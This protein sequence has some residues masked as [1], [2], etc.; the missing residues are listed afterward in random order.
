VTGHQGLGKKILS[1]TLET[2]TI[3]YAYT[4]FIIH[5]QECDLCRYFHSLYLFIFNI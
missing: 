5:S 1:Q 2:S 4:V 3:Q